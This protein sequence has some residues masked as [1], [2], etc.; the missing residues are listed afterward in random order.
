MFFASRFYLFPILVYNARFAIETFICSHDYGLVVNLKLSNFLN[1]DFLVD[2][3]ISR[4]L[5]FDSVY[6]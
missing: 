2:L 1:F 3:K 4:I 5:I 6:F